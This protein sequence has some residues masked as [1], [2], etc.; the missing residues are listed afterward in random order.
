MTCI[1]HTY[2]L[3]KNTKTIINARQ[4]LPRHHPPTHPGEML[5]EKFIKPL[6]IT[7]TELARHLD[8]P[9]S[10]LNKIIKGKSSVTPDD[11]PACAMLFYLLVIRRQQRILAGTESQYSPEEQYMNEKKTPA[12]T[13]LRP[14]P[15]LGRQKKGKAGG[16]V[17]PPPPKRLTP[18]KKGR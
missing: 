8:I 14:I 5:A 12:T 9:Y 15:S 18:S 1:I 10:R 6:E 13:P 3:F 17:P 11:C 4:R 7:K 2:S 16:Y